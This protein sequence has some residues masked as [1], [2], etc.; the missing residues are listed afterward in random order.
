M[1]DQKYLVINHSG[2][3]PTYVYEFETLDGVREKVTELIENGESPSSIRV[4]QEIPV[5]IKVKVDVDFL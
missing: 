1:S 2:F 4:T 5:N 3:G